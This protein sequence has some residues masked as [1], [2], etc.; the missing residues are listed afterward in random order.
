MK[1]STPVHPE[2]DKAWGGTVKITVKSGRLHANSPF[3]LMLESKIA[4]MAG[5]A[6][7]LRHWIVVPALGGSSPLVCPIF[8]SIAYRFR[9]FVTI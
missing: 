7:W 9:D 2:L 3:G 5:V 4:V 8:L 1:V 6:K